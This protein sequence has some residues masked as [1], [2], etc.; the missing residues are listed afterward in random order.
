MRKLMNLPRPVLRVL[1]GVLAGGLAAVAMR[2]P[3]VASWTGRDVAAMALLAGLTVAGE[4]LH[5]D[6]RFGDQT[7]HVSVS[8]AFYGAA[9][10]MGVRPSVLTL[11]V[12][13]GVVG[14]YG[15]R[16]I[17]WYK[18]AFN[19]GSFVLAVTAAELVY[20]AASH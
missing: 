9:L 12:G 15:S 2:L 19:A 7:K 4:H 11:G 18:T 1:A 16:R 20:G 10:L 6:V 3:Q 17:A 13:L 5:V 14:V 8:E